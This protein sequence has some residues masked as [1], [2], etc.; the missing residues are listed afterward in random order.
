VKTL[1]R[2]EVEITEFADGEPLRFTAEVDVRPQITLPAPEDIKVTVGAVEVDDATIDEQVVGLQERFATLKT[3]ERSAVNGDYVQIDLAA[4]VNGAEV[5]GGSATNVSHEVGSGKLL[6]GLDEVLV[7][8]SAGDATTFE[9]QLVGG[10]HAG[11]DATVAVTVRSVKE[12]QLPPLDDDFA[13]LAS[14][15]DTLAE[16]RD[17]VRERLLRVNRLEKLY[18]ARDEALKALIAATD[19]P[20]PESVVKEEVDSRKEAMREQLENAG[21]SWDEYLSNQGKTEE[22]IDSELT[23]TATEAV[24]VQLLLDTFA[25]AEEIS[26]SD[27]EFGHEIMHRAQRAGVAPQQYY[28]QLVRAGAAGMIF[29]DVRRGKALAALMERVVIED[30]NGDRL[31]LS[32]LRGED[33]HAGHD[34]D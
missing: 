13:Q 4:S 30:T 28:D 31:T 26:V 27:D 18:S 29:G 11:E 5:E 2:P 23:Q 8:R 7:G 14:E 21:A 22:E 20:A 17:D 24:Q 3:V 32:D 16:L 15:F 12:K 9:T 25:D 34:H 19:V 1:G 10:E 33:D 6:P